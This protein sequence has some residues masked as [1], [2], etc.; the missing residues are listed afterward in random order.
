MKSIA[1]YDLSLENFRAKSCRGLP[2]NAARASSRGANPGVRQ[3]VEIRIESKTPAPDDVIDE[4]FR[5]VSFPS[6]PRV[7]NDGVEEH[8][9][10]RER[11]LEQA[12]QVS[13]CACKIEAELSAGACERPP[14]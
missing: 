6:E 12:N 13:I 2:F 11:G 10:R 5:D 8:L 9:V 1:A 4:R 3:V 14:L 7:V